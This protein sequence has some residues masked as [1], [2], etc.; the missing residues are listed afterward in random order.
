M[1]SE[2]RDGHQNVFLLLPTYQVRITQITPLLT[3]SL[4]FFD[5]A[6][7]IHPT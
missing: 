7:E 2:N 4:F 6:I 5:E 3:R 1:L